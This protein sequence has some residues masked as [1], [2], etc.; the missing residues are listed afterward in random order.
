MQA[1]EESSGEIIVSGNASPEKAQANDQA[2]IVLDEDKTETVKED[3]S[4]PQGLVEEA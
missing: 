1:N 2:I 3:P 4:P